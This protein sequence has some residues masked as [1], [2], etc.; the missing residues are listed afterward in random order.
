MAQLDS[1]DLFQIYTPTVQLV[2]ILFT[3]NTYL[4]IRCAIFVKNILNINKNFGFLTAW[5]TKG[6]DGEVVVS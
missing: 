3:F 6:E 5:R 2:F 4:N 1:K